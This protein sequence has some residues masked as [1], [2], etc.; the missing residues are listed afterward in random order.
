MG[1]FN[2]WVLP[3]ILYKNG[4]DAYV[5]ERLFS[6]IIDHYNHTSNNILFVVLKK[7]LTQQ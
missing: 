1:M 4:G 5:K 2:S 3:L 7:C 6:F